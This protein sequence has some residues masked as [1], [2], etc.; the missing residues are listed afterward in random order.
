MLQGGMGMGSVDESLS[1]LTSNEASITSSTNITTHQM[2]TNPHQ[3][4][5]PPPSKKRRNL[6]GNPGTLNL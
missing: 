2:A 5:Q 6:P 1:N 3:T 4:T